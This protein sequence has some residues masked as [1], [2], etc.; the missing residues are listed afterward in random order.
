MMNG[1]TVAASDVVASQITDDSLL[2][3]CQI[4]QLTLL[5]EVHDHDRNLFVSGALAPT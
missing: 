3:Y 1:C 2:K 5:P 4:I